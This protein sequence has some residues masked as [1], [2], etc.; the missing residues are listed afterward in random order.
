M[1]FW[2]MYNEAIV[3]SLDE[4]NQIPNRP[5]NMFVFDRGISSDCWNTQ[6]C[7]VP[8]RIEIELTDSRRSD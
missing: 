1:D 6:G 4:I 8:L 7:F 3:N 2:P 5:S